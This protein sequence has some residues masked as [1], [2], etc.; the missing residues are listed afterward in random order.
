MGVRELADGAVIT[1]LVKWGH[2]LHSALSTN[3]NTRVMNLIKA[4]LIHV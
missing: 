1:L 4:L 2:V 3:Y